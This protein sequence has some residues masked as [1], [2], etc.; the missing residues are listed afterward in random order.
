MAALD[1]HRLAQEAN[2]VKTR[3][4]AAAGHDLRQPVHA[5][6]LFVATLRGRLA[7]STSLSLLADIADA[8]T[9]MSGLLER[10]MDMS[11]IDAGVIVPVIDRVPVA[12]M[13]DRLSHEFG[14]GAKF[15]RPYDYLRSWRAVA[16][17]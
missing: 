8:A 14:P 3:F 16:P 10:L 2:R 13:F 6:G 1:A 11:Q 4:L 5:I 9:A 15:E 12:D 7:N 17:F